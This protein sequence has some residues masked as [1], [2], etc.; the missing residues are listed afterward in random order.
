MRCVLVACSLFVVCLLGVANCYYVFGGV[1]WLLC[2]GCNLLLNL[3]LD[4]VWL[5]L[6]M[7]CC[8]PCACLSVVC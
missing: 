3:G 5:L 4:V 2:V 7:S 8:A 6:V 1:C